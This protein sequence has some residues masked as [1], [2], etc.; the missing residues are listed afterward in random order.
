MKHCILTLATLLALLV[1]ACKKENTVIP[2][3]VTPPANYAADLGFLSSSF[4]S[5][6]LISGDSMT[7]ITIR[8][9]VS[10]TAADSDIYMPRSIPNDY[11]QVFD[12]SS[13]GNT[14]L[15]SVEYA[16][17]IESNATIEATGNILIHTHETAVL[18]YWVSVTT[19]ANRGEYQMHLNGIICS[20]GQDDGTFETVI[21]AGS[22][23][24]STWIPTW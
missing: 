3:K 17:S 11:K 20:V 8:M 5:P 12:L 10:I 21:P 4:S 9:R 1:T 18:Q 13:R 15:Y 24:V 19:H 2:T 6:L 22:E 16:Q 14:S 23:F 7:T